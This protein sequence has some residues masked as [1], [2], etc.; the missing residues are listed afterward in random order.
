MVYNIH[1]YGSASSYASARQL[2]ESA[3]S[4]KHGGY[5]RKLNPKSSRDHMGVGMSGLDVILRLYSTD[6][7]TWH[8]DNTFTIDPY[9]SLTT[10][11]FV[12]R[13]TPSY[14][15]AH[16]TDERG[17]IFE[18]GSP[19]C[20]TVEPAEWGY[21]DY[22]QTRRVYELASSGP[23]ARF[24]HDP[25]LDMWVPYGPE[26]F[27]KIKIPVVN[28][29]KSKLALEASGYYDFENWLRAAIFVH[30]SAQRKAD[31]NNP[32]P[33]TARASLFSSGYH[34]ASRILEA[35]KDRALWAAFLFQSS[36]STERKCHWQPL[37]GPEVHARNV[38]RHVRKAIYI[39]TEGV[40]TETEI[41]YAD[42]MAQLV[43]IKR[44]AKI[45]GL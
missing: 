44:R 1:M 36:I 39:K 2:Y 45:Y 42:N 43:S 19:M 3:K 38:L 24:K 15:W 11:R 18:V 9:A 5:E 26:G 8:P 25:D 10:N 13:Y 22:S 37:L 6:C 33:C 40:I 29:K 7:V 23:C 27:E 28:R 34:G 4:W 20:K 17:M 12:K 32:D 31:W 41:D 21:G 16:F 35:L 14:C 30:P